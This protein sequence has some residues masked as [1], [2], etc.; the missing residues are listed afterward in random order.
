MCDIPAEGFWAGVLVGLVVILGGFMWLM[1]WLQN[2][3]LRRAR[4]SLKEKGKA[5]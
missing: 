5:S 2:R 3:H 1:A 4:K